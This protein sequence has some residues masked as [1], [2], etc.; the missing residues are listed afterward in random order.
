LTHFGLG[1]E[2][3][4]LHHVPS[5][6]DDKHPQD[7]SH[8][9]RHGNAHAVPHAGN[10]D[11][12]GKDR[13]DLGGVHRTAA[14]EQ[15]DERKAVKRPDR[16]E[17][18]HHDQHVSQSWQGNVQKLAP[19]GGAI[20]GRR[21]IELLV[22]GLE[23]GQQVDGEK[24]NPFPQVDHDQSGQRCVHTRQEGCGFVQQTN[25]DEAAVEPTIERV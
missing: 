25:A 19:L 15:E 20:D 6:D 7:R 12:I 22:N 3:A 23:A 18:R 21:L 2:T 16:R 9:Q 17:Q 13:I 5:Q 8:G 11:L 1:I 24:G 10:R 4:P 14:G